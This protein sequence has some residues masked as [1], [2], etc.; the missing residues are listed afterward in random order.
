M[1]VGSST[2][3]SRRDLRLV[4]R[5]GRERPLAVDLG[6]GLRLHRRRCLGHWARLLCPGE[7]FEG[8]LDRGGVDGVGWRGWLRLAQ[9]RLDLQ[10]QVG[11]SLVR[12]RLRHG[13]VGRG[14]LR[15]GH[16]R[17]SSCRLRRLRRGRGTLPQRHA[18]RRRRLGRDLQCRR[19]VTLA[20]RQALDGLGADVGQELQRLPFERRAVG[21]AIDVQR[22]SQAVAQD[23][24]HQQTLGPRGD[25]HPV[26]Q[27]GAF[28]GGQGDAAAPLGKDRQRSLFVTQQDIL[29]LAGGLLEAVAA[30]A[31]GA[32]GAGEKQRRAAG[33][34]A[35]PLEQRGQYV[36]LRAAA[37]DGDDGGEEIGDRVAGGRC[38]FGSRRLRQVVPVSRVPGSRVPVSRAAADDSSPPGETR[39]PACAESVRRASC[40]RCF[41]TIAAIRESRSELGSFGDIFSPVRP[42][43]RKTLI[44]GDYSGAVRG[45]QASGLRKPLQLLGFSVC[46][47]PTGGSWRA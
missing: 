10:G 1:G 24:R 15:V 5:D 47:A 28:V 29:Y 34:L 13:G 37:V 39:C 3:S 42:A 23:E 32:V 21:E 40:R 16:G 17:L 18:G 43:R 12:G 41:S 30:P 6:H 33:E 36:L 2:A 38:G 44:C 46:T 35:D 27:F 4:Q 26:A 22:R 11:G 14:Y 20:Q 19:L 25:A 7:L 9:L 31:L 8:H 45:C